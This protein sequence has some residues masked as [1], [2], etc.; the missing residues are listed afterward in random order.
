MYPCCSDPQPQRKENLQVCT[1]RGQQIRRHL[2]G[3]EEHCLRHAHSY[4]HHV[5][6]IQWTLAYP[7]TTGPD[8]HRIS[9]IA[10]Y[11]NHHANSIYMYNVSLLAPS[12][13]SIIDAN[14]RRILAS[15]GLGRSKFLHLRVFQ[16]PS[17]AT[18]LC[19]QHGH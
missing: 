17:T 7:A 5:T 15:S 9:E 13:V 19:A 4:V 3:E 11:V 8:H 16:R 12:H 1:R 6:H 2:Q 18:L 14:N 10:G